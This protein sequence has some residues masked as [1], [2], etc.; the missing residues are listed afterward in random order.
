V[1]Q[2]QG[3][4]RGR[5]RADPRPARRGDRYSGGPQT[6][7]RGCRRTQTATAHRRPFVNRYWKVKP[8]EKEG[9][10]AAYAD[11]DKS[12]ALV[13]KT[14]DRG[15]V[16]LFTV[17]LDGRRFDKDSRDWHNYWKDSSFGLVL[18]NQVAGYLAGDISAQWSTR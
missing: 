4:R 10:I 1:G 15:R 7:Q 18:V 13:E 8:L 14:L 17:V 11:R 12:P 5:R 16:V 9:V 3:L 6:L 2:P